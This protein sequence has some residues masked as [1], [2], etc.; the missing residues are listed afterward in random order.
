MGNILLGI[1]RF[2]KNKNTITII[3]V[4]CS[5]II[6]YW[7]Y[8]YRIESATKPVAI[9]YAVREIAPGEEI[10]SDMI[11]TKKVPGG[12]VG[13]TVLRQ[14]SQIVGKYVVNTATIP[15]GSVFYSDVVKD[16]DDLPKNTYSN[17]PDGNTIISISV[18]LDSTY[19]NSIYPGNYIDLYVQTTKDGKKVICKLIESI[20]VLAVLDSKG[21][22]V[23][24]TNGDLENPS[25]L[26]FHVPESYHL[27][28]RKITAVGGI[29][30]FPVPRNAKYSKDP[31]ETSIVSTKF[32]ED[33]ITDK[34]VDVND[35]DRELNK[36]E[37]VSGGN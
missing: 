23:F 7:A 11:S 17:I 27:L 22:N 3:A 34:T 13:D 35:R 19:G 12:I 9:P 6:L 10:T 36:K 2:F 4:L 30:M 26:V 14:S 16:W 15:M 8:N 31:K 5:L 21:N 1:K 24:E 20:K 25:Y 18:T 28:I 29:E 33:F 37:E 32:I